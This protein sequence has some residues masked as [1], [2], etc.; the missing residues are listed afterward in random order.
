MSLLPPF[1]TVPLAAGGTVEAK[2]VDSYQTMFLATDEG[3]G[4]VGI[5]AHVGTLSATLICMNL[6]EARTFQLQ[7]QKHIN[8]LARASNRRKM[9]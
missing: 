6:D 2:V 1:I 4:F 8:T 3:G 5:S 9:N 7:L